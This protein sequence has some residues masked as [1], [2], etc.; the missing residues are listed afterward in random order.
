MDTRDGLVCPQSFPS[1]GTICSSSTHSL[2]LGVLKGMIRSFPSSA[3]SSTDFSTHAPLNPGSRVLPVRSSCMAAF[4][5]S[6]FLAMSAPRLS[7]RASTSESAAAMAFCSEN[8]GQ[9]IGNNASLATES[10]GCAEDSEYWLRF[11]SLK[12]YV[13]HGI[14][15]SGWAVTTTACSEAKKRP[16]TSKT[17]PHRAPWRP[18]KQKLP[19]WVKR[20]V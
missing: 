5:I 13:N 1:L 2:H 20:A 11:I 9:A 12:T 17:F 8:G 7:S 6:R 10:P 16:F 18:I 4:F 15:I 19:S 3:N 14:K